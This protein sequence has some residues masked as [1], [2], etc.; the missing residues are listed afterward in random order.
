M[1]MAA[2]FWSLLAAL[3]SLVSALTVSSATDGEAAVELVQMLAGTQL[4]DLR[5]N[6]NTLPQVKRPWGFND[7]A[8]HTSGN[9]NDNA[10]W[11]HTADRTFFGFKCSH[12]PSPWLG[13]WGYFSIMPDIGKHTA[14]SMGRYFV[15]RNREPTS[16]HLRYSPRES[17]WKPYLF[18]TALGLHDQAEPS[19]RI[20][21][22]FTPTD[23]AGAARVIFPEGSKE[24]GTI[25][26]KVP[27]G[28]SKAKMSMLSGYT[29]TA[30][31]GTVPKNFKLYFAMN[32]SEKIMLVEKEE[33]AP[34]P[35][36]FV[37]L[38]FGHDVKKVEIGV[39]TSL[40]SPAQVMFN[41]KR[42]IGGKSFES[43][44]EEGRKVWSEA[45]GRVSVR[46]E[47][48]TQHK[49]F[50]TNLWKS[51]LFP[52]F[53]QETDHH[54]NEVHYSPFNGKI[55][56]GKMV[57]DSGFWD[58][59]HTVYPLNSIVF[60]GTLGR[61]MDG[62]VNAFDENG[63]IPQWASP[64]N[65]DSMVGTMSDVSI[66][67][68]IVKSEAGGFSFD[69]DKAYKAILKD[70]VSAPADKDAGGRKE[71]GEYD[72]AGFVSEGEGSWYERRKSRL[73]DDK[74]LAGGSNSSH[75]LVQ[76][77]MLRKVNSASYP[78]FPGIQLGE[79]TGQ[80][81]KLGWGIETVARTLNNAV[82]DAAVARA[83][84]KL[85][86]TQVAH[87]ISERSKMASKVLFNSRSKFFEPKDS[88]GDFIGG[89]EPLA[90]R[91]GFTEGSAYHYRFY[92]PHDVELLQK[93]FGGE[94]CS[95][96]KEDLEHIKPPAFY[97]GGYGYDIHE[98]REHEAVQTDFGM[99][100]HCNQPSHEVLWVAKKAGCDELADKYLRR[101]M[102]KL[103]TTEGWCGDEDNGE[104]GAWYV[105][106]ALGIYS[107]EGAKDEMV[108]GSPAV[109]HA[110]VSLPGDRGNLT[111]VAKNQGR[112]NV[113]V[114]SVT[115]TPTGGSPEAV[116]G[117]IIK[118]SALMS[119]G[120][121]EFTMGG[122]P[123]AGA[124]AQH[125]RGSGVAA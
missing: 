97:N 43:V 99:Y 48:D 36:S 125:L 23:H 53:L 35:C 67:D 82:A 40:I 49:V 113:F 106:S 70:A 21:F 110:S 100:N 11:F 92:M 14:S 95:A 93:L 37:R 17:T 64:G 32:F 8:P 91:R 121:L 90:W 7:W 123:R 79:R 124:V 103:Y 44:V 122:S 102:D 45:M 39:A 63:W 3:L 69:T 55:S 52:R 89:F 109:S 80:N 22:E 68:A 54:G 51:M 104:M 62:W 38:H 65:R 73:L 114:Q 78:V 58:A 30:A 101:V 72:K 29:S 96:I 56:P 107:L 76:D 6:G 28:I 77:G 86:H 88:N 87:T 24:P 66:A 83:A 31:E 16:G 94:L 18:K 120:T 98:M 108:L 10:W 19:E 26:V 84:E 5:S 34:K 117:N 25:V 105:L 75:G 2:L 1:V 71:L 74:K 27:Q 119:G 81:A 111:V 61:L 20:G 41:L 46:M 115:W 47:D 85:G 59:Y 9:L 57:V 15:E 42:E 33:C 112:E 4:S 12:Q 50:Y 116:V 60:P 118:Y 13:D